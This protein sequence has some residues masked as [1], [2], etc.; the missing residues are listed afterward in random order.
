VNQ[1]HQY[2][3]ELS[4][5]AKPETIA[6]IEEAIRSPREITLQFYPDGRRELPS[7]YQ[8]GPTEQ[9]A[10]T[11]DNGR[12]VLIEYFASTD[13]W[14]V[15]GEEGFRVNPKRGEWNELMADVAWKS[16]LTP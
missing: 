8:E 9:I 3:A 16:N 7:W 2:Q 6:K 1:A 14:C 5:Q 4:G 10:C 12:V 11:L 15:K 13:S